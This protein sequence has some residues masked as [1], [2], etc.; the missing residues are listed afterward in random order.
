M[1]RLGGVTTSIEV[2]DGNQDLAHA[3]DLNGHF[4]GDGLD[5]SGGVGIVGTHGGDTVVSNHSSWRG[6]D[7]RGGAQNEMLAD[8]RTITRDLIG[9]NVGSGDIIGHH[10]GLIAQN[11]DTS[12]I[13]NRRSELAADFEGRIPVAVVLRTAGFAAFRLL[14]FGFALISTRVAR[15]FVSAD[16]IFNE[17]RIKKMNKMSKKYAYVAQIATS[18]N[19]DVDFG[20]PHSSNTDWNLERAFISDYTYASKDGNHKTGKL[21]KTRLNG[22]SPVRDNGK[23]K[24]VEA[25]AMREFREKIDR[26]GG[27]VHFK[28][29]G[30]D[31]FNRVLIEIYDPI[32]GEN[33]NHIYLKPQYR[34]A[35][36][37]YSV[38]Y[39]K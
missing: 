22:V 23:N 28:T 37:P 30:L 38:G 29:F 24:Y 25:A 32:T 16:R 1:V 11:Q 33:L 18:L 9:G 34:R 35:F 17:P 26:C 36:K 4:V 27:F 10:I 8:E 13:N 31:I 5:T 14:A 12:D 19:L 6:L 20:L 2:V 15:H 39:R 21:Y 7:Q 3:H